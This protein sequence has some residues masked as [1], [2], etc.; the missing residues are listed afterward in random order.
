M[1]RVTYFMASADDGVAGSLGGDPEEALNDA[2]TLVSAIGDVTGVDAVEGAPEA[3]AAA[4]AGV[5]AAEAIV[6]KGVVV[7]VDH[8]VVSDWNAFATAL[9]KIIDHAQSQYPVYVPP[10]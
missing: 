4:E 9:R 7:I 8:S 2:L 10:E 5:A 1:A 3:V 6:N